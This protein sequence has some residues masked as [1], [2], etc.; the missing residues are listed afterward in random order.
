MKYANEYNVPLPNERPLSHSM[1]DL[2]VLPTRGRSE[3]DGFRTMSAR[4]SDDRAPLA[5]FFGTPTWQRMSTVLPQGVRDP[6]NIDEL[7][8]EERLMPYT[9]MAVGAMELDVVELEPPPR[10]PAAMGGAHDSISSGTSSQLHFAEERTAAWGVKSD[11]MRVSRPSN[12]LLSVSHTGAPMLSDK[13]ADTD[14]GAIDWAYMQDHNLRTGGLPSLDQVLTRRTR[15]P[16][17]LRDFAVHCSVRQPQA[18][19]WL[20]FYMAARTH[21]KMC[22]AYESDLRHAKARS[23]YASL[24]SHLLPPDSSHHRNSNRQSQLTEMNEKQNDPFRR[25]AARSETMKSLSR[26]NRKDP[27]PAEQVLVPEDDAV[28]RSA[29][30]ASSQGDG[31]RRSRRQSSHMAVQIQTAAETIFLRYFRAALDPNLLQHAS[32]GAS[33]TWSASG[34]AGN[35]GQ[36]YATPSEAAAAA[37]AR[38]RGLTTANGGKMGSLKRMLTQKTGAYVN[39]TAHRPV[40]DDPYHQGYGVAATDSVYISPSASHSRSGGQLGRDR[41]DS[42]ANRKYDNKQGQLGS[43]ESLNM[44]RE[45]LN[46][47][48]NADGSAGSSGRNYLHM[49]QNSGSG[50]GGSSALGTRG[51]IN[52]FSASSR[53]HLYYHMPWPPEILTEIEQRLL[54]DGAALDASLFSEALLYAYDVLDTYYFPIFIADAVSRN[55]TRDH[56][57]LRVLFAFLLL[58]FG[59][60]L[61]L[62]LILLDHEP[63]AQRAW[64]V[65]PQFFGWWNMSVGFG[66]CDLLLAAMRR[67]QSPT[68][69]DFIGQPTKTAPQPAASLKKMS[70]GDWHRAWFSTRVSVDPTATRMVR[71]RSI[72]WFIGAMAMTAISLAILC[73]VPGTHI[74]TD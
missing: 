27:N 41:N 19:R 9:Q 65:I 68:M 56:C 72:R 74:Y 55:V 37:S 69:K 31:F 62:A 22:L 8:R 50:A 28:N 10:M 35:V 13:T 21:E 5:T 42:G 36:T 52:A 14:G 48:I 59:F 57:I 51:M 16:L 38:A 4:S 7:E 54:H 12:V 25:A 32:A 49:S 58:W 1:G 15:A 6:L 30:N 64:S 73:A 67:Y 23:Q 17:A 24:D 66:G 18:R 71:A 2:H 53:H 3:S 47:P 63:K 61:P 11:S 43:T 34:G 70:V 40:F 29:A 33:G 44:S 60:A 26:G 39:R 20:E 46:T 45:H